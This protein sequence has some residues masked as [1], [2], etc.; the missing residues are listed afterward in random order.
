MGPFLV[1][2]MCMLLAILGCLLFWLRE[3]EQST[4]GDEDIINGKRKRLGH[5]HDILRMPV[6]CCILQI[7]AL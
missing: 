3:K 1:Y 4:L 5:L 6:H 2:L 7:E